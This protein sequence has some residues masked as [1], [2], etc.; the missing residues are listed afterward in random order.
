M[1]EVIF[2]IYGVLNNAASLILDR[3]C[4][5]MSLKTVEKKLTCQLCGRL[6]TH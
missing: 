5:T 2:G 3:I 6:E 4:W 1:G